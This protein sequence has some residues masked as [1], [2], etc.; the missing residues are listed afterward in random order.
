MTRFNHQRRPINGISLQS[1]SYTVLD[2]LINYVLPI[3]YVIVSMG[4][5]TYTKNVLKII[6]NIDVPEKLTASSPSKISLK[7]NNSFS[8]IAGP[9]FSCP[10]ATEACKNCYAM[11]GHHHMFNVQSAL[12][13]NWLL[14]R[15]FEKKKDVQGAVQALLKIIPERAKIFRIHESGDF[16]SQW[17]VDVWAEVIRRR[18]DINF[19]AYTRSFQFNY[20]KIIRRKNF[21]LWA[22]TDEYNLKEANRFVKRYE[23]SQVKHAYGPWKHDQEIPSNSFKCPAVTKQLSVEGAC[24]KC[25]LCVVKD[26]VKKNVVFLEH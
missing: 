3:C 19:W 10:G 4:I 14:I 25:M 7:S 12:A 16:H 17:Y 24:E 20:S 15:Q 18:S 23:N 6:D 21:T 13:K 22:S 5:S 1:R 9:E 2:V 26:R 11:K 8:M